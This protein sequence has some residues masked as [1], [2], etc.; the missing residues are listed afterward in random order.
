MAIWNPWRGCH[1]Y[2]EGCKFCYTHKGDFKKGIDTNQIIKTDNFYK[3][4]EKNKKGLYKVKSN[5]KIYTCFS[6]DFLIEE[7]DIWRKECWKFI[8]ERSDLEFI[9]LTKRIERFHECIPD[10]WNDGYEN[11]TIGCTIEN[12]KQAN[13]RL[14]IFDKA[15][16][17]HKIIIFQ[18]L[19]EN[20]F[21]KNFPKNIELIVVGGESD[22]YGRILDYD[23]VLNIR[24]QAIDN[25]INFEFRQCATNF[26]KNGKLYKLNVRSLTAQ[27]KK[28]DINFYN[29]EVSNA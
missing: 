20:I 26:R 12:Q 5:Q 18:P 14:P 13:I 6:S 15:C 17:K 22:K 10:D 3:P 7:A 21:I 28:A 2:S 19:I 25:N 4:I 11:V 1:K 8:K 16:I 24:K 27:A 29:K 9:F 23:W